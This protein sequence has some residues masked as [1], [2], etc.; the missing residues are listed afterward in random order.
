MGQEEM[1]NQKK[2]E[3]EMKHRNNVRKKNDTK[4]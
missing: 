2:I 3:I 1:L 4:F